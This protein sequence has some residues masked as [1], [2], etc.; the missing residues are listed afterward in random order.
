MGGSGREAGVPVSVCPP[1]EE[2]ERLSYSGSYGERLAKELWVG[3]LLSEYRALQLAK[4]GVRLVQVEV[5]PVALPT[6]RD[7]SL[8]EIYQEIR[9]AKSKTASSGPAA[10]VSA[11]YSTGDPGYL[12]KAV[13]ALNAVVRGQDKY[14]SITAYPVSTRPL[15]L[16]AEDERR[17]R[18]LGDRV[19]ELMAPLGGA[20]EA[21]LL[22]L[23]ASGYRRGVANTVEG[24]D[25]EVRRFVEELLDK[26]FERAALLYAYRR[27]AGVRRM[28]RRLLKDTIHP[29]TGRHVLVSDL[30][31]PLEVLGT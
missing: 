9:E 3:C 15:Q 30:P 2:V 19:L 23:I 29:D 4:L 25:P 21:V 1:R 31:V 8:P 11:A 12:L 26:P 22:K 17:V 13:E 7:P 10:Y 24:L 18:E 20:V 27:V 6:V 5:K 28:M 14:V 16:T